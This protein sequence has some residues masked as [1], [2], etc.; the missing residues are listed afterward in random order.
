VKGVGQ[1]TALNLIQ[2][3]GSIEKVYLHL[4]DQAGALRRNLEEGREMARLSRDL[5]AIRLD[6]PCPDIDRLLDRRY[7]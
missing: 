2:S 7:S 4:E 5:A 3:Y 1:K 6:V